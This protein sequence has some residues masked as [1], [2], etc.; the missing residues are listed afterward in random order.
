MKLKELLGD[1]SWLFDLGFPIKPLSKQVPKPSSLEWKLSDEYRLPVL[2]SLSDV[3]S[4]AE[5]AMGWSDA[6]LFVQLSVKS[7]HGVT[8]ASSVSKRTAIMSVYLDTRWSPGVHRA[9]MYC[10]R[11]ELI[12]DRPTSASPINR[13]HG[14]LSPIQRAR[15]APNPIHPTDIPVATFLQTDGYTIRTFLRSDVLTGFEPQE[16]Q[17]IGVFYSID[18]SLAG[19]QLLARTRNCP[20]FEDPSVWCRGKLISNDE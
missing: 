12:L 20:Y 18:D 15:A 4:F 8:S 17:D 11:F 2:N 3:K 7:P 16:Y 6:G 13:G 14:E 10:H 5:F 9:S 19:S 1:P